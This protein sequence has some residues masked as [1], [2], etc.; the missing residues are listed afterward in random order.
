MW[1]W[2]GVEE[3]GHAEQLRFSGI[4]Q[5]LMAANHVISFVLRKQMLRWSLVYKIFIRTQCLWREGQEAD[6]QVKLWYRTDKASANPVGSS[7]LHVLCPSCPERAEI[8]GPLYLGVSCQQ[9]GVHF[10]DV[11]LCSWWLGP[12]LLWRGSEW[13]ICI[14]TRIHIA[15]EGDS[16]RFWRKG[17]SSAKNWYS[18]IRKQSLGANEMCAINS[19]VTLLHSHD[20]VRSGTFKLYVLIVHAYNKYERNNF[21]MN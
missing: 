2:A 20:L 5:L 6:R 15:R 8:I 13:C 7:G 19:D 12:V 3:E 21:K 18:C 1:I 16:Q 4:G 17:G 14:S 10:G 11:A 9:K